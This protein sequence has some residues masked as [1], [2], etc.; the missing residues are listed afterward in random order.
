MLGLIDK[1]IICFNDSLVS[2][3]VFSQCKLNKPAW[4]TKTRDGP[5]GQRS[6]L[7]P[8]DPSESSRNN[9]CDNSVYFY[10]TQRP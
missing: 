5:I 1:S 10:V 8:L 9:L 7:T 4:E 2:E 3:R 6:S